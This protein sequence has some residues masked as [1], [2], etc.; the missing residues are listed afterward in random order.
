MRTGRRNRATVHTAVEE[1]SSLHILQYVK[2]REVCNG[3]VRVWIGV[4]GVSVWVGS[5][6]CRFIRSEKFFSLV[7]F[8]YC[9]M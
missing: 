5:R 1:L 6:G 7:R 9:N 2:G 3:A 8:T 4:E